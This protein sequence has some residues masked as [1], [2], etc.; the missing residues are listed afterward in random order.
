MFQRIKKNK[1]YV[2]SEKQKN[3]NYNNEME[4]AKHSC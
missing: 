4:G 1:K 2:N 3:S